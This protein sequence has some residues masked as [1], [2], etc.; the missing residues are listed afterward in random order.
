MPASRTLRAP[1]LLGAAL[2]LTLPGPRIAAADPTPASPASEV[3]LDPV[4]IEKPAPVEFDGRLIFYVRTRVGDRSA[5]ER[6]RTI[7]QRIEEMAASRE[8]L[9]PLKIVEGHASDVFVGDQFV[10]SITEGDSGTREQR[11]FYAQSVGRRIVD[12]IQRYR[13]ERAPDALLRSGG[14]ALAATAVL[15]AVLVAL[16]FFRRR[17]GPQLAALSSAALGRL[18]VQRFQLIEPETQKRLVAFVGGTI[19]ALLVLVA[20]LAWADAVAHFFP[21]T[22][23]PADHALR[24]TLGAVGNVLSDVIGFLPN[25]VYILLFLLVGWGVQAA[26]RL[27][28]RAVGAGAIQIPGFY[29]DWS[30]TTS[31]LVNVFIFALVAVA[32]YPYLP[33]S[34]SSAFQ[35]IGLL[36][37]AMISLGSGSAVANA[38]SGVVLTYMRPFQLGD[39]VKIADATGTVTHQSL[40][41]VRLVTIR[42]EHVTLPASTVLSNPIL[43]YS[44][45]AHESGVAI[46]TSVTIGYDTPWRQVHELLLAAAART[47]GVRDTPPPW[48]IQAELQDFYVH[49]ELDAYV[50][51]PE[52]QHFILSA[53]HQAVQDVFFAAGVEILSPHYAQL[54]DGS[55]PAIP[56]EHAPAGPGPAFPVELRRPGG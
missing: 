13:A 47:P 5:Q 11:G 4:A 55:R 2:L 3:L 36:M 27:F 42:N 6:A 17:I 46:R 32:I 48:V 37:G 35:A 10:A 18:R 52:R 1:L 49:Y 12:G 54:R 24:F 31:L 7:E 39:F 45:R 43:N 14:K 30:R 53:L 16:S 19:W 15:V 29:P 8:P 25:L 51:T 28:F 40:L 33:G 21:W 44:A 26:N 22:R 20:L 50:D 38:I 34:G 23:T 41:A 56:P 9:G